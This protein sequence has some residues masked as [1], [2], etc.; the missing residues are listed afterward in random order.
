MKK[1]YTFIRSTIGASAHHHSFK[2]HR[3]IR[4]HFYKTPN[5]TVVLEAVNGNTL[6]RIK[7][8]SACE[9]SNDEWLNF[10]HDPCDNFVEFDE[11]IGLLGLTR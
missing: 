2:S 11:A 7:R 4:V 9:I 5:N 6:N 3:L 8:I 1:D 10:A